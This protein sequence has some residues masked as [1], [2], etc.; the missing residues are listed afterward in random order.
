MRNGRPD[1]GELRQFS[2]STF[3]QAGAQF[4]PDGRW[5]TYNSNE[6]GASEVYVQPF[7]GP[8]EKRRL[9]SSGGTNPAWSRNGRELFFLVRPVPERP[10]VAMMSVEVSTGGDFKASAP[11]VLF[12]GPYRD[13]N[14]L[15]SYDVT[16]D[17]QFIM[18]RRHPPPDQPVTTLQVV[19]GW[20][21]EL[22]AK[23]PRGK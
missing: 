1:A 23:V 6:S 5:I 20:A 4:S 22:L 14:P 3:H 16:A 17:G 18:S 21:E 11:R 7:P 15:R 12:E 8:G 9:S 13:T 19:L 10:D 2:P